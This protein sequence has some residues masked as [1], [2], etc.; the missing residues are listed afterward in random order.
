MVLV[1]HVIKDA[2]HVIKMMVNVIRNARTNAK[3][4][5]PKIIA[6]VNQARF[7]IMKLSNVYLSS[8][9][10]VHIW[11]MI[12]IGARGARKTVPRVSTLLSAKNATQDSSC[13]GSAPVRLA[14]YLIVT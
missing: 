3:I 13:I 4:V 7:T 6:C 11:I 5:I 14:A 12:P 10:L 1:A 8:V 9:R 2:K